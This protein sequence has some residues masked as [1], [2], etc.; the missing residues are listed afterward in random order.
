MASY[1]PQGTCDTSWAR[2]SPCAKYQ[3]SPSCWTTRWTK[4]NRCTIYWTDWLKTHLAKASPRLENDSMTAARPTRINGFININKARGGTSMD[5]VR[6]VKRLTDQKK[7]VGHGGTLDP[8]AEGVLAICFGQATRLMEHLI[9]GVKGYYMKVTLGTTTSTY[10]S[11]GEVVATQD[12]QGITRDDIEQAVQPFCGVIMQTPPMYSALKHHGKRLYELARAGV[13]VEREPRRVEVHSIELLDFSPP[14]VSLQVACGRGVYMRSLAH[15]LGQSLRC[16][17]YLSEL[18][19]TRSGQF[20]V[21]EGVALEELEESG[22]EQHLLPVDYALL[23]SKSTIVPRAAERLI[24]H[25]RDVNL[26]P[27]LAYAGYMERYRAYTSDGRFLGVLR[28][29]KP[30]NLWTPSLVFQLDTVSPY[31]P[32]GSSS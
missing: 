2:G 20:K 12:W 10:D 31:C 24:R 26:G 6:R 3:T 17:G 23:D 4:P 28:Y 30:E 25:G 19:R 11:E 14:N 9:D 18:V 5:V 22:W 13:E 7:G 16:G 1:Q 27:T 29:N 8:Q 21:E 32:V 15:D